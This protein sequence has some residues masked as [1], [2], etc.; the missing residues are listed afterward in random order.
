MRLILQLVLVFLSFRS[1]GQTTNDEIESILH[2]CLIKSYEEQQVNINK[3][4]DELETY[5]IECKFLKSPTGQSYFDFFIE[6]V[7]HNDTPATLDPD[8][9]ENIYKLEPNEFYKIDCLEKLKDIDPTIIF[10]SKFFHLTV[11]I[12]NAALKGRTPS[13]IA[14]AITNVLGPSDFDHPYFRAIALLCIAYTGNF[15]KG[16]AMHFKTDECEED[17][18]YKTIT[19]AAT[20]QNQIVLDGKTV[21]LEELKIR[22]SEF[23]QTN[24]SKH[25]IQLRVDKGTTYGFYLKIQELILAV[26][27]DLRNDLAIKQFNKPFNEL[28]EN[29]QIELIETYPIR[30]KDM[31]FISKD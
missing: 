12:Q 21:R 2:N 23:I 31:Y 27:N 14:I 29:Q 13:N 18:D 20:D 8:R 16:L 10:K 28:T 22:L 3:E 26:Y 25:L 7:K 17:N 11:A 15:G 1:F 5:L 4:L 19:V 30:L 24:Q 6:I 9:F